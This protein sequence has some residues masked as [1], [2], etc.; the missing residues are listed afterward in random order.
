MRSI[1]PLSRSQRNLI[2]LFLRYKTLWKT[3]KNTREFLSYCW[4]HV[5]KVSEWYLA[6]CLY[7]EFWVSTQIMGRDYCIAKCKTFSACGGLFMAF[8]AIF[9]AIQNIYVNSNPVKLAIIFLLMKIIW[10]QKVPFLY[11]NLKKLTF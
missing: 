2:L 8:L 7:R 11:W 3:R 4:N 10:S 1:F 6:D 9:F 5:C